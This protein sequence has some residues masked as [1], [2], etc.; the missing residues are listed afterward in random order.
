[1]RMTHPLPLT[2]QE[3]RIMDAVWEGDELSSDDIGKS[4]VMQSEPGRLQVP[5]LIESLEEKGWLRSRV[6]IKNAHAS[7]K[8]GGPEVVY[9]DPVFMRYFD[10][11]SKAFM[12]DAIDNE[13]GL[14]TDL[15]CGPGHSTRLLA[16]LFPN[17]QVVGLDHSDEFLSLAAGAGVD[18]P[19]YLAHD[20]L[21]T[22]YPQGSSDALYCR[23]VLSHLDDPISAVEKWVT[24]LGPSGLL[25]LEEVELRETKNPTFRRVLKVD[26]G[27]E[28]EG[29]YM[30]L[31]ADRLNESGGLT[32]NWS[33]LTTV[34]ATT[35]ANATLC[36]LALQKWKSNPNI[37]STARSIAEG[38]DNELRAAG[39]D[40]TADMRVEFVVRQ[41]VYRRGGAS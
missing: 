33:R 36:R 6:R 19:T 40:P 12:A 37:D 8:G 24:Q 28:L 2:T 17:A 32:K 39:N 7:G 16:D 10:R 4:L 35:P 34:T 26:S 30:G 9:F 31:V 3:R 22:P 27:G 13:P 5:R 11:S 25:A 38:I 18:R 41:V 20:I 29:P 23:F 14:I 21:D 15:G 1:M